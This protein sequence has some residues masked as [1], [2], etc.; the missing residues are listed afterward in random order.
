M[1]GGTVVESE[2]G[3][4]SRS[5]WTGTEVSGSGLSFIDDDV[6]KGDIESCRHVCVLNPFFCLASTQGKDLKG[7]VKVERGSLGFLRY[8][9]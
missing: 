6:I 7:R 8:T 4:E 5:G 3:S 9:A 2:S 1:G